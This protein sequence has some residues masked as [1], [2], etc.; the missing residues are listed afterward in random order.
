M[1]MEHPNIVLLILDA[2]RADRTSVYGNKRPTT[3]RIKAL[4]ES[5]N[6]T[7]YRNAFANS[8]WTGTSHATLFTGRLPSDTGVHGANQ[9]IPPEITTL[10]EKLSE[11]GYRTFG[12]SAG[13][14]V[15]G[16]RGYNRGIQTFKE[17]Y[18]L[19]PNKNALSGLLTD[20]AFRRQSLY[21]ITRG[22][23][24][25]TLF[26]I[27]SLKRWIKSGD[28]PFFAFINAKTAHH[29]YNPPRPHKSR[30]CS[31]LRRPKYQF[32][33]ELL[34]DKRGEKQ[35]LPNADWER[36]QQLSYEY[37]VLAE[38]FD[39]TQNEWKIIRSWY[40]GALHYLDYRVGE[41]VDWLE[42]Q[43]KLDNTY[44]IITAD[45]GEYFG[46]HGMEKHYYGLYEPVL[47]IPLVIRAPRAT[48]TKESDSIVS[49]A[50]LY[51]TIVEMAT[52]ESPDLPHTASMVPFDDRR[53]HDHVFA[54][55]GAVAPDGIVN[56]HPHFEDDGLGIPTQVAR[57]EQYKLISK[58]DGS[59]ELYDWRQDLSEQTDISKSHSDVV[60]R[61]Q[62]VIKTE[63]KP[64]SEN[65]LSE[66][67]KDDD[68]RKHLED[69]GYM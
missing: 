17:T 44:L 14:H 26:K 32:I 60:D 67:I 6:T 11:A 68:L 30:F 27:E 3:P 62:D 20:P 23:D 42:K 64:L 1:A 9:K 12:M 48:P 41:L 53:L 21:S 16:E 18:R 38:E 66:N 31:Q 43:G 49:L 19:R 24:K 39:P 25:K 47:H 15:R 45:H 7:V 52:G 50:D 61:L 58:S 22:P 13:A 56:N 55:L 10:P 28:R 35:S 51:P 34:G 65:S 40:D 59:I 46:E 69:L 5:A 37:P 29:P 57:D 33:E 4:T 2:V 8:N 63:L 54:E 36:L